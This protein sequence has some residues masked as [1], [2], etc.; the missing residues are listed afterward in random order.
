LSGLVWVV[1][2]QFAAGSP[3]EFPLP[4]VPE[5]PHSNAPNQIPRTPDT[6]SPPA[7]DLATSPR[8]VPIPDK[9]DKPDTA[10]FVSPADLS[11]EELKPYYNDG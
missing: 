1:P 8:V 4:A 9:P 5:A 2:N 3:R 7:L 11:D 10:P 6:E